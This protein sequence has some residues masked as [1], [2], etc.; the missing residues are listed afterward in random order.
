MHK[1]LLEGNTARH[2]SL[3]C[4]WWLRLS[5][6]YG[7]RHKNFKPNTFSSNF[8][9][10]RKKS[11]SRRTRGKIPTCKHGGEIKKQYKLECW[12]A[13]LLHYEA[14]LIIVLKV[15]TPPLDIYFPSLLEEKAYGTITSKSRTDSSAVVCMYQAQD[16]Q[17]MT[18]CMCM[19]LSWSIEWAT[20]NR[21]SLLLQSQTLSGLWTACLFT[22]GSEPLCI[23]GMIF[24]NGCILHFP[25]ATQIQP[26]CFAPMKGIIFLNW[27]IKKK[28]N[29]I[30]CLLWQ[31][32]CTRHIHR[33]ACPGMALARKTRLF[34]L[35]H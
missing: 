6:S 9:A 20:L 28:N 8:P 26:K 33:P 25:P 21:I 27:H 35:R 12:L 22:Y 34:V 11:A 16:Y 19:N 29:K 30:K 13:K 5:Y 4:R 2:Y 31:M 24:N 10:T 32:N 7:Y 3:T 14:L 15:L 17:T 18:G 1:I 23:C